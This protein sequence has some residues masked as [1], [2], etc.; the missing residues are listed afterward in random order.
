MP[1]EQLIAE[2]CEFLVVTKTHA[3]EDAFAACLEQQKDIIMSHLR[4]STVTRTEATASLK[5]LQVSPFEFAARSE[6]TSLMMAKV[7]AAAQTN[8]TLG[9]S[10]GGKTA[11]QSCLHFHKLIETTLWSTLQGENVPC[12]T[13]L[14]AMILFAINDLGLVHPN[15]TTLVHMVATFIMAGCRN[16]EHAFQMD[17]ESSFSILRELKLGMRS[18]RSKVKSSHSGVIT[19]YPKDVR[20]FAARYPDVYNICYTGAPHEVPEV[21]PVP[22]TMLEQF[23]VR[24]PAR[25]THGS[26]SPNLATA[27]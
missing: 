16:P 6:I 4:S 12:S 17:A 18:L 24:L 15:E 25:T 22:G 23:R 14:N 9:N 10:G 26:V 7:L 8:T 19:L 20:E 13:R 1:V 3:S 2:V 21:C 11:M 5:R 27:S